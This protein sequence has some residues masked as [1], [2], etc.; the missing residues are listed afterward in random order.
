MAINGWTL[1]LF[2]NFMILPKDLVVI[3]KCCNERRLRVFVFLNLMKFIAY[4][5]FFHMKK[6]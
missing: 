6:M 5:I 2:F 1:I 4:G 3:I